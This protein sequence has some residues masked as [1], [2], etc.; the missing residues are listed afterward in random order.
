MV[1]IV[2]ANKN[3]QIVV[4][5]S[6]R[7]SS[8]PSRKMSTSS[9]YSEVDHHH[10]RHKHHRHHHHEYNHICRCPFLPG[11][12][13]PPPRATLPPTAHS[14]GAFSLFNFIN[15]VKKGAQPTIHIFICATHSLDIHDRCQLCRAEGNQRASSRV[16]S[17]EGGGG[18]AAGTRS[19]GRAGGAA[20]LRYLDS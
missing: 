6:R 19:L 9:L 7:T 1:L 17:R 20:Y 18:L 10:H 16:R 15:T 4:A 2:V 12:S 3:L 11:T 8:S 14:L 5:D 13:P